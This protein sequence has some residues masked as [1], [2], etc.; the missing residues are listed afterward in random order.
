MR[1]STKIL[2]FLASL[3]WLVY[4]LQ[5]GLNSWVYPLDRIL[6]KHFGLFVSIPFQLVIIL[7][8]IVI[9]ACLLLYP[10][11]SYLIER[12]GFQRIV[13]CMKTLLISFLI[14]FSVVFSFF[15][16]DGFGNK[17]SAF[18]KLIALYLVV[19][20]IYKIIYKIRVYLLFGEPQRI[21]IS[22]KSSELFLVFFSVKFHVIA[23]VLLVLSLLSALLDS[24]E[25]SFALVLVF[26]SGIFFLVSMCGSFFLK[27]HHTFVSS[28]AKRWSM[29]LGL[30][31]GIWIAMVILI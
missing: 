13:K 18:L 30:L 3:L 22:E 8:P 28:N 21:P 23:W 12:L 1:I 10:I 16:F 31:F 17:I 19:F 26:A 27:K 9:S 14:I 5:N 24:G 11:A 7:G 25:N 6:D 15:A 20:F 29:G 4:I 2:F